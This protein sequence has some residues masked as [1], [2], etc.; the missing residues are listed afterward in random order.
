MVERY[1][2]AKP[3]HHVPDAMPSRE[4]GAT[5]RAG[6]RS[7]SIQRRNNKHEGKT[8]AKRADTNVREQKQAVAIARLCARSLSTEDAKGTT[9]S[10]QTNKDT[11]YPDPPPYPNQTSLFDR[12]LPPVLTFRRFVVV[13]SFSPLPRV[14]CLCSGE[15]GRCENWRPR[16]C[17]EVQSCRNDIISKESIGRTVPKINEQSAK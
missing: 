7:N 10:K 16:D 1:D 15:D 11:R 12:F 3:A 4:I 14:P 9:Q 17:W 6:I 8:S 5:T 2:S 13:P